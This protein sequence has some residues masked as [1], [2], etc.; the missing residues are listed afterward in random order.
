MQ[1]PS[2]LDAIL[3]EVP[4]LL[5]AHEPLATCERCAMSVPTSPDRPVFTAAA[6]CCTFHP[7]LVNFLVGQA[8][9][10]GGPGASAIRRRL[11][12][13]DGLLPRGIEPP[14]RWK[15]EWSGDIAKK[16]GQHEPLTC[17]YWVEGDLGCGIHPFRESVCRTWHCRIVR[18]GPGYDAWMAGR[19]LLRSTERMVAEA[20]EHDPAEHDGDWERYY[21]ACAHRAAA[22]DPSRFRTPRTER[23]LERLREGAHRRDQPMPAT[24]IPYVA[25][26]KVRDDRVELESWSIYDPTFA[27]PWVFTF[28]SK[29]DG[30]THW[31]DALRATAEEV[32]GVVS[33]DLAW[34]L[35]T[36]GLL[37]HPDEAV[38]AEPRIDVI[39]R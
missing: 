30:A 8:L 10:A 36:R 1:L 26:W 38:A 37:A 3:P 16:F 4:G 15:Q 20:V 17:P 29:L 12:Q 21:I 23:L 39:P 13:P 28:L 9:Q 11:T 31:R 25:A 18:G 33:P 5:P 34:Q 35:W 24:P 7:K 14:I 2:P 27:P 19:D 32:D 22:L 6:R